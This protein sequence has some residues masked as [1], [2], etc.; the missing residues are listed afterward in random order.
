MVVAAAKLPGACMVLLGV[1]D[2]DL[3][4]GNENRKRRQGRPDSIPCLGPDRPIFGTI[5]S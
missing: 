5:M 3:A 2:A 1:G 4:S